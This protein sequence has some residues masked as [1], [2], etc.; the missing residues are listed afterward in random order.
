MLIVLQYTRAVMT[1]PRSPDTALIIDSSMR[2]SPSATGPGAPTP[3]PTRPRPPRSRPRRCTAGRS[4][5]TRRSARPRPRRRARDRAR[6]A[7]AARRAGPAAEHG[8][9]ALEQPLGL[10]RPA[11]RDRLAMAAA[12]SK[13][14]SIA[15]PRRT[16]ARHRS[17]TRSAERALAEVDAR[18]RPRRSTSPRAP[19]RS[20]SSTSSGSIASAAAERCRTPPAS[21]TDRTRRG[22]SARSSSSGGMPRRR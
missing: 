7:L 9:H 3:L 16:L 14:R 5:G 22:P 4:A 10:L 20:R 17:P 15:K 8:S 6:P 2:R 21:R 13:Q 11:E 12:W 1:V 18:R 19:A